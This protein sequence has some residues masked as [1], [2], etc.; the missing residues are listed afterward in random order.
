MRRDAKFCQRHEWVHGDRWPLPLR[1]VVATATS[2][3][4]ATAQRQVSTDW[5]WGIHSISHN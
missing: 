5:P 4:T 3:C 2:A 1:G